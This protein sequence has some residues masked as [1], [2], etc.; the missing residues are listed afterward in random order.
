[1]TSTLFI[2]EFYTAMTSGFFINSA[3]TT[4]FLFPQTTCCPACISGSGG[5]CVKSRGNMFFSPQCNQISTL[6]RSY[7]ACPEFHL[8]EV[9][10]EVFPVLAHS[11]TGASVSQLPVAS[12][13]QSKEIRKEKIVGCCLNR[14]HQKSKQHNSLDLFV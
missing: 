10:R 7:F 11:T 1:M 13:C 14:D 4:H 6:T 2:P 9:G 12:I 5:I 8:L 3:G